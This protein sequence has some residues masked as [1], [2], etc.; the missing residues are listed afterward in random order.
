ML[1][2]HASVP[3]SNRRGDA[4]PLVHQSLEEQLVRK[5]IFRLTAVVTLATA[6]NAM[7]VAAASP[8]MDNCFECSFYDRCEDDPTTCDE[9]GCPGMERGCS[10][11]IPSCLG[12]VMLACML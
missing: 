7:P 2:P 9:M 3:R 11:G 1:A 8:S 6:M 10:D 12:G 5:H 4:G